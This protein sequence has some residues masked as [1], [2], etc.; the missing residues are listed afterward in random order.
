MGSIRTIIVR[1][2]VNLLDLYSDGPPSLLGESVDLDKECDLEYRYISRTRLKLIN[3]IL[4]PATMCFNS[5]WAHGAKGGKGQPRCS[6]CRDDDKKHV[7]F[8][9]GNVDNFSKL[10]TQENH[11]WSRALSDKIRYKSASAGFFSSRRHRRWRSALL[12]APRAA[13][14]ET[15]RR[16]LDCRESLKGNIHLWFWKRE[17]GKAFAHDR[18]RPCN[19]IYRRL[20]ADDLNIRRWHNLSMCIDMY[21]R[22]LHHVESQKQVLVGF[23]GSMGGRTENFACNSVMKGVSVHCWNSS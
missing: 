9:C 17:K 23:Q 6:P 3:L 13:T 7:F 19:S 10:A 2:R 12:R 22:H 5:I 20:S 15:L 14:S 1:N 11:V 8:I 16:W 21:Y 18:C 4:L